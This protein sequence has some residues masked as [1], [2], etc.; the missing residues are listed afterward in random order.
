MGSFLQKP[1]IVKVKKGNIVSFG[2]TFSDSTTPVFVVPGLSVNGDSIDIS[3]S[4]VGG[5]A[6]LGDF[7]SMQILAQFALPQGG[8]TPEDQPLF[9]SAPATGQVIALAPEPFDNTEAALPG[10][11]LMTAMLQFDAPAGSTIRFT[12]AA[13]GFANR[14]MWVSLFDFDHDPYVYPSYDATGFV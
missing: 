13:S 11:V 14:N 12:R 8:G 7:K 5:A 2:Y 9:I 6:Q 4:S 1:Q 3:L 10:V